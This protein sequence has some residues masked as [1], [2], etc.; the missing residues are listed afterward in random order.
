MNGKQTRYHNNESDEEHRSYRRNRYRTSSPTT[1]TSSSSSSNSASSCA[2]SASNFV[3]PQ[4]A[5]HRHTSG[6]SSKHS[7]DDCHS[8]LSRQRIRSNRNGHEGGE[9]ENY[10]RSRRRPNSRI[11]SRPCRSYRETSERR[12]VG[13]RERRAEGDRRK[14]RVYNGDSIAGDCDYSS[15]SNSVRFPSTSSRRANDRRRR[16]A[17]R[18]SYERKYDRQNNNGRRGGL[19]SLACANEIPSCSDESS[20]HSQSRS[21]SSSRSPSSSRSKR[22]NTTR[23]SMYDEKNRRSPSSHSSRLAYKVRTF[24]FKQVFEKLTHLELLDSLAIFWPGDLY[25]S[26]GL[27]QTHVCVLHIHKH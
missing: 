13:G 22:S 21:H 8:S 10:L 24:F 27:L 25:D 5:D 6:K 26:P 17:K 23:S 9:G 12:R 18:P 2:S 11:H 16:H 19:R 15:Q 14:P 4:T 1:T 3:K 20:A 7:Q